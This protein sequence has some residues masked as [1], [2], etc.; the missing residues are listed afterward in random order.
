MAE[1]WTR[2]KWNTRIIR[3]INR[4]IAEEPGCSDIEPLKEVDPKHKWHKINDVKAAQD[5][6][7]EIC[8]ENKFDSIPDKWKQSIIDELLK[9]IKLG[10]CCNGQE[11]TFNVVFVPG[12]GPFIPAQY[13]GGAET[14]FGQLFPWATDLQF[15]YQDIGRPDVKVWRTT[16][17]GNIVGQGMVDNSVLQGVPFGATFDGRSGPFQV[18]HLFSCDENL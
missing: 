1:K 14:Y 8:D 11:V 16:I 3:E 4:I 2:E 10:C 7:I 9:A 18:V 15:T 17:A 13:V 12:F 5:K 6:L